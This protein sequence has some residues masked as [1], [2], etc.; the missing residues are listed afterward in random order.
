M[1][2]ETLEQSDEETWPD[3]HFDNSRQCWLILKFCW[4]H[5]QIIS[6]TI[7]FDPHQVED[8]HCHNSDRHWVRSNHSLP[9]SMFA[10]MWSDNI[11]YPTPT[12]SIKTYMTMVMMVIDERP[13]SPIEKRKRNLEFFSLVSREERETGYSFPQFREEKEKSKRIFSTFE[14]RKRNGFSFLKL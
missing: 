10:L 6:I 2:F 11:L 14:R 4:P 3:Q 8:I 1:T 9:G 5:H 7:V 12:Q 13:K